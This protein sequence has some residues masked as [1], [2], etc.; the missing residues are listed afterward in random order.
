MG[1]F[2]QTLKSFT[3]REKAVLLALSLI[4]LFSAYQLFVTSDSSSPFGQNRAYTEGLVGQITHLN[5]VFTEFSE[6]DADICSLIFSGLAKYNAETGTFE[7]DMA[8]H[9]LSEDKL[10]YT[11]TLKNNLFWHDGTPVTADDV[12]YTFATVIQSPEF[13]N[14]VLKANFEGVK[15]EKKDSRTVIFTLNSKNSFFFSGMT[16]GILPY[17]LLKDVPVSE[18]DTNEFNKL[19]IGTGPYQVTEAYAFEKDGSTSLS[20]TVFPEYYGELP[21]IE[22]LRFVAYSTPEELLKNRSK[23]HGAAR[24]PSYLLDEIDLKGLLTY[25]YELP[26]YTALFLNTDSTALTKNAVRKAIAQSID[27]GSIL[28]ATGYKVKID[29]PILEIDYEGETLV[30]DTEAAKKSLTDA[31]WVLQ[32]GEEY[33]KNAKG[34]TFTLLLL[35]RDYSLVNESQEKIAETTALHIQEDLA[36]VGI[37]VNIEA[38]PLADLQLRIQERDYDLLLYGQSLGYNLDT[39]S[40]WHSSQATKNGLNL[41]NYQNAKADFEIEEVRS[42]F[43]AEERK[44]PLSELIKI[45]SEDVPAVFL[46]TPSYY[47]LADSKLTGVVL[48]NILEPKDR[49]SNIHNWLFN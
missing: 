17:H 33:R 27:K 32:E 23:W 16:V 46:Y 12:Y 29:H 3:R 21:Q 48:K 41:S 38:R 37:E 30:R 7:E 45:L 22:T 11:F 8:T 15:V 5:P 43:S 42:L 34:E 19:P 18:L 6:A 13:N 39:F 49:F 26:Q 47:Y 14:P 44:E 36:E 25:E 2:R 35:R 10:V 31:G 1:L 28:E 24:I 9:T 40:Y 20:L 4:C